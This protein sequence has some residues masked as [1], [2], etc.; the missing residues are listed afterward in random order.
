MEL[1]QIQVGILCGCV[2][3]WALPAFGL[4]PHLGELLLA[5]P[6][7]CSSALAVHCI[8]GGVE[9]V[10]ETFTPPECDPGIGKELPKEAPI[11]NYSKL[12]QIWKEKTGLPPV[13]LHQPQH[14]SSLPSHSKF[15]AVKTLPSLLLTM[16]I[17]CMISICCAT[18]GFKTVE[19]LCWENNVWVSQLKVR[20]HHGEH[21][22]GAP[23]GGE[24][25]STFKYVQYQ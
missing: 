16:Q 14:N 24:Q 11:L 3:I 15:W 2:C 4:C 1:E 21:L 6:E 12:L 10:V 18:G 23:M 20:K 5:L 22:W 13:F 19:M 8:S 9:G 17:C 25:G 7:S